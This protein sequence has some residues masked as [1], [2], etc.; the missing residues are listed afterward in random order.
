MPDRR[1]QEAT[2]ARNPST[3][4]ERSCLQQGSKLTL[5]PAGKPDGSIVPFSIN[6]LPAGHSPGS[7]EPSE[8]LL[9]CKPKPLDAAAF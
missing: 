4:Q 8:G 6:N 1:E 7:W 2:L 5:V 9:L 3:G